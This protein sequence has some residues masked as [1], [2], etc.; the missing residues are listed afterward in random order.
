MK[1]TVIA[2]IV[3][4]GIGAI[5]CTQVEIDRVPFNGN[6]SQATSDA[7]ITLTDFDDYIGPGINIDVEFGDNLAGVYRE[8][9]AR[10]VMLF[11]GN[12]LASC[13]V[14]TQYDFDTQTRADDSVEC[15]TD[16]HVR[17]ADVSAM[18]AVITTKETAE[19]NELS[20]GLICGNRVGNSFYCRIDSG[21]EQPRT[22]AAREAPSSVNVEIRVWE[23]VNDPTSNYISARHEGGSWRTLGTIPIPLTDGVS[24]RFRYGD[25]EITVPIE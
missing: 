5:A 12:R 3:A 9:E 2:A 7:T 15:Y 17:S 13:P 23:N 11:G 25:I 20:R 8:F 24:G 16:G 18:T 22:P 6:V 14:S 10:F 21:D 4:I 1:F 19:S